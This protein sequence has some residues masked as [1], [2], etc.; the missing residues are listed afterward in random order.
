MTGPLVAVPAAAAATEGAGALSSWADLADAAAA[1]HPDAGEIA[2]CAAAAGLDSLGAVLHPFDALLGAGFGWLV[3]H[4]EFLRE[5]LDVLAGDPGRIAAEAQTWHNVAGELRSAAAGYRAAAVP[6]WH[7]AAAEAYRGDVGELTASMNTAAGHADVLADLVLATGA[8]V[9]TVRAVVRDAIAEFLAVVVEYL[10]A[11]GALA[12]L[13]AGGSLGAMVATVVVR[14]TELAEA[15]CGRLAEL[16]DALSAAGTAAGRAAEAMRA[17]TARVRSAAPGLRV[18]GEA[19]ERAAAD[20]H[21]PVFV[22]AGKQATGAA[23][24]RGTWAEQA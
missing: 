15:I 9:G 7:G 12:V 17:A 13:T 10:L 22:E 2:F 18:A 5:P 14:A 1:E 11:A 24:E 20:A 6:G 8:A 19:F 3:E 23:Q 4:V 21:A 16:L